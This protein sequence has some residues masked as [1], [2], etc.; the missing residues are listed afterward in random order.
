MKQYVV[1]VRRHEEDELS[2]YVRPIPCKD[3]ETAIKVKDAVKERYLKENPTIKDGDDSRHIVE[4]ND[5]RFTCNDDYCADD[6]DIYVHELDIIETDT[7]IDT[8]LGTL[9]EEGAYY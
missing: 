8:I 6:I 3:K 9:E 2:D 1:T 5:T 7:D 4:D